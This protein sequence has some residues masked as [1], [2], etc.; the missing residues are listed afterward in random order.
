[1]LGLGRHDARS[2]IYRL[3]NEAERRLA[4]LAREVSNAAPSRH[5]GWFGGRS[6]WFGDSSMA[7]RAADRARDARHAAESWIDAAAD[8]AHR[9]WPSRSRSSDW[10]D[11]GRD[12]LRYGRDT[13]RDLTRDVTHHVSNRP[14][15]VLAVVVGLGL[16]AGL[17]G[18][19]ASS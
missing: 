9:W 8:V 15:T 4:D 5:G 1:M 6:S 18:R 19:R 17:V 12:A 2:E 13:A 3:I 16:L 11:Y 14:M 10:S 7:D